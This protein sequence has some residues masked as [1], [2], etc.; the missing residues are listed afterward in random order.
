MEVPPPP[1][2]PDCIKKKRKLQIQPHEGQERGGQGLELEK[3]VHIHI[4]PHCTFEES[5]KGS[6]CTLEC[7]KRQLIAKK[8][9]DFGQQPWPHYGE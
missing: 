1:L 2:R 6:S 4:Q 8:P 5:N 9:Q 7:E 3:V